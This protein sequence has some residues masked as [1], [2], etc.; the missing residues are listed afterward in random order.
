MT[1]Q[2]NYIIV[3]LRHL[4]EIIHDEACKNGWWPELEGWE[5]TTDDALNQRN[6]L[7]ARAKINV[8]EKLALV[9]S[10][11]SEA[12]EAARKP[13]LEKDKHCPE[14][15]NFDIEL[16]DTVIRL[17]DLAGAFGIDLGAAII[18]KIEANKKRPRRHGNKKY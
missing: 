12:L 14:F 15:D 2:N 16:A 6:L 10:E 8:A 9:H 7:Q 13:E 3:S 17:F 18:A 1:A 5:S 4:R 11:I